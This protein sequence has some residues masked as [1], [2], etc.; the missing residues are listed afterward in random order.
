MFANYLTLGKSPNSS[1]PQFLHPYNRVENG[2]PSSVEIELMES[3]WNCA[4]QRVHVRSMSATGVAV[5]NCKLYDLSRLL[6]GPQFLPLSNSDGGDDK[7]SNNCL[8]GPL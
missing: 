7:N 2:T 6:F 4:G 8:I 5:I 3:M 1:V